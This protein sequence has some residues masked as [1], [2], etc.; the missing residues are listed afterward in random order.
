MADTKNV[1]RSGGMRVGT[2][3]TIVFIVLKLT[4]TINWPWIWVLSPSWITVG[5][6][7]ILLLFSLPII[8]IA[9]KKAANV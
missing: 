5:L 1:A 2:E 6:S 4:D 8:F 9:A 3:L 7:A